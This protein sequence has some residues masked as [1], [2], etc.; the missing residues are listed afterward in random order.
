MSQ[1]D[2][3]LQRGWHIGPLFIP[4][5]ERP[6]LPQMRGIVRHRLVRKQTPRWASPSAIRAI[7]KEARRLTA[8]TGVQHSVDHCIPLN[9]PAVCGLHVENNLRV[10][11]L[12]ANMHKSNNAWPD[13]PGEQMELL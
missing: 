10:M 9:H 3:D 6:P 12:A 2:L 13:M 5:I 11:P 7:F 8:E 4:V 1:R